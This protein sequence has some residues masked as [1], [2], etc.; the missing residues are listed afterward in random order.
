MFA[1][2]LVYDIEQA[3][4]LLVWLERL[5]AEERPERV[6]VAVATVFKERFQVNLEILLATGDDV[7]LS[8][9][10]CRPLQSSPHCAGPAASNRSMSLCGISP[11]RRAEAK[12]RSK[13]APQF[14]SESSTT[15]GACRSLSSGVICSPGSAVVTASGSSGLVA[16]T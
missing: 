12:G 6:E 16:S 14:K 13:S 7:R 2:A 10:N 1:A 5:G 8:R 15:V 4:S 11:R 9:R 3:A